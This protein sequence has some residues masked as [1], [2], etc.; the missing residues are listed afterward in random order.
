M[1]VGGSVQTPVVGNLL[2]GLF[3]RKKRAISDDPLVGRRFTIAC[4][5]R[6][7]TSSEDGEFLSLCGRLR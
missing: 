4:I 5:R 1:A 2:G 6:G 3:G 7:E